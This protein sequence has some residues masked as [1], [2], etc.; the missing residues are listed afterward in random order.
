MSLLEENAEIL[1]EMAKDGSD[2][3]PSRLVDFSHVFPSRA[4][5]EAF[6]LECDGDDLQSDIIETDRDEDPWDVNVSIETVPTAENLT[7]LEER[8]D[9]RARLHGGRSDGWGFFRPN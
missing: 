8:L 2:L 7:A 4:A 1:A 3:G 9:A 6:R 5:A